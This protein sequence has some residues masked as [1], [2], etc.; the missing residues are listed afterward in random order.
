MQ[1]IQSLRN[2]IDFYIR[3]LTKFSRK[4]YIEEK[5]D[6]SEI[7]KETYIERINELK[8]YYN[9]KWLTENS[10]LANYKENLYMLDIL[11]KY[12]K[13]E[14]KEDLKTL[15]IGCKNWVY[16]KGQYAFFDEHSNHLS[17]NGI[18]IDAHRLYSNFYSRF[19]VAK[20]YTKDLENSKYIAG[21]FLNYN[22]EM[23]YMT[24]FLPF[25]TETPLLKWGLPI[26]HFCPK[27][28][29]WHAYFTL[30]T[31]GKMFIVNQG[32]EE[33]KI[34]KN[35]LDKCAIPYEEI[36]K[37]ESVFSDFKQDRY[38]LVVTKKTVE[39]C[40]EGEVFYNDDVLL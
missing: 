3:E 24:W 11:H 13:I 29:L 21:N 9:F 30:K 15:D 7:N 12:F 5:E 38:A 1:I 19:E 20:F 2:E 31:G 32:E 35:Y 17:F 37:I 18:E 34:Q 40:A 6:L 26:Q 10:T 39:E 14:F 33:F 16:A 36:G 23:D 28:M 22:E 27:K 4:N 8:K 25:V